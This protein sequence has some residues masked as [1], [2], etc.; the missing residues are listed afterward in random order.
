MDSQLADQLQQEARVLLEQVQRGVRVPERAEERL[1][2]AKEVSKDQKKCI[3]ALRAET[4]RREEEA[5]KVARE[6]EALRQRKV[7]LEHWNQRIGDQRQKQ[8]DSLLPLLFC[9]DRG[10]EGTLDRLRGISEDHRKLLFNMEK[11]ELR[12]RLD[13][14]IETL[15]ERSNDLEQALTDA[16]ATITKEARL[17][18]LQAMATQREVLRLKTAKD[19]AELSMKAAQDQEAICRQSLR[20]IHKRLEEEKERAVKATETNLKKAAEDQEAFDKKLKDLQQELETERSLYHY[21]RG[22]LNKSEGDNQKLQIDLDNESGNLSKALD[23][24]ERRVVEVQ[25]LQTELE[26]KETELEEKKTKLEEKEQD[27]ERYQEL[28]T[29][30]VR[31]RNEKL[32]KLR[33]EYDDLNQ[34]LADSKR[35]AERELRTRT[36]DLAAEKKKVEALNQEL[37]EGKDKTESLEGDLQA[38]SEELAS[39]KK[40]RQDLEMRV[41]ELNEQLQEK[42]NQVIAE[43]KKAE[44]L[45]K[46]HTEELQVKSDEVTSLTVKLR[47][48]DVQADKL[49]Q[50]TQESASKLIQ[51]TTRADDLARQLDD[52]ATELESCVNDKKKI[53]EQADRLR[54]NVEDGGVRLA[55]ETKRADDLVKQLHDKVRELESSVNE[56]ESSELGLAGFFIAYSGLEQRAQTWVDFVGAAKDAKFMAPS[57]QAG[58]WTAIRPCEVDSAPFADVPAVGVV[59]LAVRLH[60]RILSKLWD[61]ETVET[62]RALTNEVQQTAEAVPVSLILGLARQFIACSSIV[63]ICGHLVGFGLWQLVCLVRRRW[64]ELAEAQEFATVFE[65][66]GVPLNPT[67]RLLHGLI[68]EDCGSKMTLLARAREDPNP[69]ESISGDGSIEERFGRIPAMYCPEQDT[70][71]ISP[72]EPEGYVWALDLANRTI[73]LVQFQVINYGDDQW[74]LKDAGSDGG[75][76]VIPWRC[77]RDAE[78]VIN[79]INI[80]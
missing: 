79:H 32:K 70:C 23:E 40:K 18:N 55:Q 29:G 33:K 52:K 72:N 50:D 73:R 60:G 54:Q 51:E 1:N 42:S 45:E 28:A 7:G 64:P 20:D 78:W 19:N 46:M 24:L 36:D 59:G 27:S 26:E 13:K 35:N 62:V 77:D 65:G 76:I 22:V 57:Q 9:G 8:F 56:K 53:N 61:D 30:M 69:G 16:K 14:E 10:G 80:G 39:E 41:R 63:E 71:I 66:D 11:E 38:K 48:S 47:E 15:Q 58:T 49:R 12:G 4:R 2:K 17:K 75:S 68:S 25:N 34:E 5:N 6:T 67:L 37:K 3:Q 31:R 44:T 43:K 74:Q 21:Q